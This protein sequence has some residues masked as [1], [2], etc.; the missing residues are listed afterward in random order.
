M[1]GSAV[2]VAPLLR[3]PLFSTPAYDLLRIRTRNKCA[4]HPVFASGLRAM[5]GYG[6][7]AHVA[8]DPLRKSAG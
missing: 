4:E 2:R 7:T 6:A 3:F 1:F 8:F 5:R